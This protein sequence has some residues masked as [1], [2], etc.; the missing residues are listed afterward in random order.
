MV[1]SFTKTLKSCANFIN[2]SSKESMTM[3]AHEWSLRFHD[4]FEYVDNLC[5]A[6]GVVSSTR[7]IKIH[8][9]E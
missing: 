1:T 7:K 5:A 9:S 6:G 4:H 3:E 2:V 8:D